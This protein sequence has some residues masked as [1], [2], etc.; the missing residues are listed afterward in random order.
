M[1]NG[2]SRPWLLHNR[3]TP[4]SEEL[5]DFLNCDHGSQ[6]SRTEVTQ[7]LTVYIRN[8]NLQDPSNRRRILCDT[9]L[10]KLLSVG[11]K[12]E[13]TCFNL[14]KYMNRHFL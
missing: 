14:S 2:R 6:V 12:D 5:C 4:I 3:P 9:V 11:P 10:A 7:Y 13:V 8:N 1:E